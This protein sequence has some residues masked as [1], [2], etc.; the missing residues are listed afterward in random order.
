MLAKLSDESFVINCYCQAQPSFSLLKDFS[1]VLKKIPTKGAI[2]DRQYDMKP[3]HTTNSRCSVMNFLKLV[4][5][6][7]DCT[8]D[9]EHQQMSHRLFLRA[10]FQTF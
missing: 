5:N 3:G 2:F 7:Y 6:G 9:Q 1:Y 8:T 10:K 4:G